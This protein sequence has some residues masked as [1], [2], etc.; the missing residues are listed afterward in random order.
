ML[1]CPVLI[2]L[3]LK[4][5]FSINETIQTPQTQSLFDTGNNP[6]NLYTGTTGVS[7]QYIL[8]KIMTEIPLA[9]RVCVQRVW[10]QSSNRHFRTRMVSEYG[11]VITSNGSECRQT[12][13]LMMAGYYDYHRSVQ[14]MKNKRISLRGKSFHDTWLSLMSLCLFIQSLCSFIILCMKVLRIFFQFNF[15]GY[16]GS[17]QFDVK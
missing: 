15:M 10:S 4:Q 16:Q 3:K 7:F 13:L 12:L 2:W 9:F 6:V 5:H 14:L 11:W 8:I 17:F 1:W